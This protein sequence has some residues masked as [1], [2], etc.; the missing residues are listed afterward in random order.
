MNDE[1]TARRRGS[2]AHELTSGGASEWVVG[3]RG[4]RIRLQV[5]GRGSRDWEWG[6]G[7]GMTTGGGQVGGGGGEGRATALRT[8]RPEWAGCVDPCARTAPRQG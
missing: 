6:G 3:L 8:Q 1:G 5:P 7:W 4:E 2:A